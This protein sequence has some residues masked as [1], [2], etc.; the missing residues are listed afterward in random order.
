MDH[1]LLL[2]KEKNIYK[3]QKLW[4]VEDIREFTELYKEMIEILRNGDINSKMSFE[5]R[6][7]IRE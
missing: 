4:T 1:F 7:N 3:K 5:V 6:C 2:I